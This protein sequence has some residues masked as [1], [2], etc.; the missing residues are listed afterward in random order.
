MTDDID[1]VSG[2]KAGLMGPF[3]PIGDSIFGALIPTIFGALAAN[4]AI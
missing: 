1:P 2:I 3:A 4:M